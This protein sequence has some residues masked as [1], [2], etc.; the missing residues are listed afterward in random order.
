MLL[1][2]TRTVTGSVISE[3]DGEPIV[4]ASVLVDGTTNGT[5][6]DVNGEFSIKVS[7]N[8]ETITI[9][10]IGMAPAKVSAK[11]NKKLKVVLSANDAVLDEVMVV[12]YGTAKKSSFTG[13][14]A[15]LKSD[16]IEA[17]VSTNVASTLAGA[18]PGVQLMT[19]SGDPSS[20][21]PKIR[22]RGI[23]SINSSNAPLYVVDG[24][25]FSGSI[26]TINPM[27]VESMTV[28]K[29]ASASAI[30]GARGANGVILITTKKGQTG[31]AK[32][33]F[34]AKF[35]SNSRLIPR[36]DVVTDPG[37]Y[38]EAVYAR[39]Y[40]TQLYAGSTASQA[41]D[42]AQKNL[43]NKD[44][45]GVGYQ[46]YTV[47]EGETLIGTNGKLNPNATLGY[48]DGK[49]YYTPDDWYDEAF[50]NS[51]RQE[52]NLSI[53][54]GTD[55]VTAYIGLGFLDDGGICDQSGTKRYT[56]RLSLEYQAKSWL[57]MNASLNYA[58]TNSEQPGYNPD[59]W[60]SSG[61][62]F[63]VTNNIGPIY[64]L[65]VRDAEGNIMY[66]NGL[67]VYDS[68]Q[69]NFKRPSL[70]GNAVR[71]NSLDF[72]KSYQDVLNGK[73]GVV[74]TP[75]KG[76]T[77]TANLGINSYNKRYN[78]LYSKFG[79]SSSVKGATHVQH[80]RSFD[81]NSQY[82]ADYQITLAQKHN[83][84][85][86]LG[87][88]QYQRKDQEL[89]GYNTHLSLPF[90]GEL[91]NAKGSSKEGLEAS[92]YTEDYMTEG[93]LS[94]V[95]YNFDEKYF[96]SGSFRRDA[97]SRF[98]PGHQWGNFGSTGAAWL[99]SKEDF[100]KDVDW[101]DELKVKASYGI[102]G[103]DNLLD[104]DG[105]E[106]F[107]PYATRK[108]HKGFD[109]GKEWMSSE[110]LAQQGNDD[111]TWETSKSFNTGIDF[112]LF[113]SRLNG[114]IE[115][116]SR[117]TSDMLYYKPEPTSSGIS[118]GV[119]PMNVGEVKNNGIE[120]NL[121][122]VLYK[123]NGIQV[124]ANVN[125]THYKNEILSLHP[126]VAEKGIRSGTR[127]Y[128][129]GGSLYQAYLYKYA[130]VDQENGMALFYRKE[131]D[132]TLSKTN[133]ITKATQFDCGSTLP[134]LFG[135]FGLSVSG[136]GFDL[137]SQFQFQL[138]GKY[139]DGQYQALMWTQNNVGSAL[140]KDWRKSW[141]PENP[142]SKY[143]R[144]SND[145]IIAQS[146]VDCFQIKSDYLSVNNITLGYTVPAK[147]T[148]QWNVENIR[149]Y[150]AGE[151]LGVLTARRGIDPRSSEGIGGYSSGSSA[152]AGNAYA[153]MRTMTA[154]LSV[155]F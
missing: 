54:G 10:Y 34:D 74:I 2:Q 110:K 28:L 56:S 130:G 108:S 139:Y 107:F 14:A 148:R 128:E 134:K 11:S 109:T 100:M 96:L 136:F 155:T 91:D 75:V 84:D 53:S 45:G 114:T 64:P 77:L 78:R 69:T 87:Y 48:S 141:T 79:S 29:D 127:I 58:H 4:G 142:S 5:V 50:H 24:V 149:I 143:P 106:T 82:I 51:F 116:F 129:V 83:I 27:D 7:T 57:R 18:T 86:M 22:I 122:G 59:S 41:Y 16:A 105:D 20:N 37:E 12:A 81:I 111:L 135:G 119:T 153:A 80:N 104:Y 72:R 6:T 21:D 103:N 30:Y 46:V 9:S 8:D 49:Y 140:H 154:G 126:D 36:Y 55:K 146:S 38:Y 70:T 42:V 125:F 68:N 40:N 98:K 112:S 73:W 15:Q 67:P 115:Y 89:Y 113:K 133:Q 99:V 145:N 47:P 31:E 25:P 101:I 3:E 1:A 132:G 118:T 102:Q 93:I 33:R 88:E 62:L 35:G 124:S 90:V 144:W 147:K 137:T 123:G 152:A 52:Y 66:E 138:G 13:S 85:V 131:E 97:S 60:G 76:L 71:D 19:T 39:L 120:V 150:V 23:A 117:T 26:S 43:L 32:V 65:Y 17:H 151:N 95:Q 61:N 92:S 94:R 44:N 121:D 63:S